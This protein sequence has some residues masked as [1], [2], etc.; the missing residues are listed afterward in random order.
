MI[1]LRMAQWRCSEH[2]RVADAYRVLA[3]RVLTER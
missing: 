1:P 3:D 2:E